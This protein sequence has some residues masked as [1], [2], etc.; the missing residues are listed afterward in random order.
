MANRQHKHTAS[1]CQTSCLLGQ[2][3]SNENKRLVL[4][5]AGSMQSLANCTRPD[6]L[7]I[8]NNDGHRLPRVKSAAKL[9]I[10]LRDNLR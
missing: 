6:H 3:V 10:R 5:V 1:F 2:V 4:A 8:K 9:G 7:I